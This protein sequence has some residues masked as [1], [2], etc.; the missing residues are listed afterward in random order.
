M[1][2]RLNEGTLDLPFDG[3]TTEGVAVGVRNIEF[4]LNLLNMR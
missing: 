2:L 3:V 1:T 4:D